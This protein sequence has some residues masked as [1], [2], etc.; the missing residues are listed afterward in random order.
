MSAFLGLWGIVHSSKIE[1]VFEIIDNLDYFQD[2]W[3]GIFLQLWQFLVPMIGPFGP[4]V[5]YTKM[6]AWIRRTSRMFWKLVWTLWSWR[7]WPFSKKTDFSENVNGTI[8]FLERCLW[9]NH[10]WAKT[11]FQNIHVRAH[12][13]GFLKHPGILVRPFKFKEKY[14]F[15]IWKH[16]F[17]S[18][19]LGR[20]WAV[21]WTLLKIKHISD[22]FGP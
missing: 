2:F 17:M 14:S 4:Q 7:N 15:E 1:R 10:F 20:K 6:T 21:F 9:S 8:C 18:R 16:N 22:F 13:Q 19:D 12:A 11:F 3:V 5:F